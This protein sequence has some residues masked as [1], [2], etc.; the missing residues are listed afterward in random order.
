[1][2]VSCLLFIAFVLA[3]VGLGGMLIYRTHHKTTIEMDLLLRQMR[4]TARL[5]VGLGLQRDRIDALEGFYAN[6][7]ETWQTKR[8]IV[9][10]R[11]GYD[12][13]AIE[14]LPDGDVDLGELLADIE[15]NI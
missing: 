2:W 14:Q 1:M 6:S 5:R 9:K 3:C 10:E 7:A 8:H 4:L 15:A 13:E 12:I 11:F